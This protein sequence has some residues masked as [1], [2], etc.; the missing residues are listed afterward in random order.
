MLEAGVLSDG[1][2]VLTHFDSMEAGE[3][4]LRT[5]GYDHPSPRETPFW[6]IPSVRNGLLR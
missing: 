6:V 5:A 2:G 1:W 3:M 4:A